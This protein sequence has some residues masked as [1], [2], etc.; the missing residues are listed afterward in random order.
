MIKNDKQMF[1]TYNIQNAIH[2]YCQEKEVAVLVDGD[3]E[4]LGTQVFKLI[5]F[6]YQEKDNWIVYFSFFSTIYMYG[7]SQEPKP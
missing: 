5:N 7:V 3:D 2:N 1:A 4:L 6:G